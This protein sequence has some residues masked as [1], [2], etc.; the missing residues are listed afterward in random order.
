MWQFAPWFL[1]Q[2]DDTAELKLQATFLLSLS[3]L[4]CDQSTSRTADWALNIEKQGNGWHPQALNWARVVNWEAL[5]LHV[6]GQGNLIRCT[7]CEK[8]TDHLINVWTTST[9]LASRVWIA[10]TTV[11][12]NVACYAV[13]RKCRAP[14]L[15]LLTSKLW[16][17]GLRSD[18]VCAQ[19][20]RLLVRWRG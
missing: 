17:R 2:G 8:R 7:K 12:A 4:Q 10:T 19:I 15:Q 6:V 1:A 9:L 13:S 20:S 16:S 18:L 3:P 5:I 11:V 14:L